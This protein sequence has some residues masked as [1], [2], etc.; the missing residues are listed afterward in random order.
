MSDTP[1][2]SQPPSDDE[3]E[4]RLRR[5][6]ERAFAKPAEPEEDDRDPFLHFQEELKEPDVST[7][8]P[9]DPEDEGLQ[10]RMDQLQENVRRV[11]GHQLPEVPEFDF[12]RPEIPGAPQKGKGGE[13][14][15]MGVGISVAYS[16]VGLTVIGW[17]IGK[18]I[19][20]RTGGTLGQALG[21]LFG[22]VAGLVGGI[23]QIVRAQNRQR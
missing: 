19:D 18:L 9:L 6:V 7:S 12:K 2:H 4:A 1:Q 22:A 5:A 13:Y 16:L 20:T 17:L 10:K 21:T 14:L 8:A 15:G 3:I 11:S 23:I